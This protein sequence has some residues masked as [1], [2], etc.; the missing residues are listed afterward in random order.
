MQVLFLEVRQIPQTKS[1]KTQADRAGIER[2]VLVC[3]HGLMV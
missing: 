2:K 1:P 3:F